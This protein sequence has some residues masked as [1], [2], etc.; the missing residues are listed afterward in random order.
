M[1]KYEITLDP[2]RQK[3]AKAY[4]RI[5]RR[6]MVVD[7]ALGAIYIL[8]WLLLGWSEALKAALLDLTSNEGLLVAAYGAVFGGIYFLID[9]PLSYYEGFVL[10]HRFGLSNQDL[11]GDLRPDQERVD[12]SRDGRFD[13]GNHLCRAERIP[14]YVVAVGGRYPAALPVFLL[15][16][17]LYELVTM[18]LTNA[19]SRWR[20]RRADQ[21]ALLMTGNPEAFASAMT[22][23][24]NQN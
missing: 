22:R 14:Q 9:L 17:G 16:M 19:Y 1:A 13:P 11:R 3:Q 12:H 2:E 10:P 23:L 20:E 5:S 6:L 18:P 8:A 21:Y 15:V 7:L 4:D 24:A